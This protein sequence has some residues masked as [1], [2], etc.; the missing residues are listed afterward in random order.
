MENMPAAANEEMR[1]IPLSMIIPGNNPRKYFDPIAMG[2]L[3]KS[4]RERGVI[5]PVRLRPVGDKYQIVAGERRVR[6]AKAVFGPDGYIPAIVKEL[7]DHEAEE[8]ALVENTLRDDMSVTEEAKAAG[9][10]L[11]RCKGDRDEAARILAWP[12]QKLSRRL[13]LLELTEEVM[14]ALDERK[15]QTGH[16]E[17]LASVPKEKQN[18]TLEKIIE[19]SLSVQ[20][21][22]D[23]LLKKATKL[24]AAIFDTAGCGSCRFNSETQ[25]SLFTEHI[26]Q[27]YC[28]NTVCFD[29]K[30][31][32]TLEALKAE[33]SEEFP[34][35]R[36]IEAGDSTSVTQLDADGNLGVGVEQYAACKSCGDF[37]AT[38]S[39]LTPNLGAVTKSVCF[40][41]SCY[42]KKVAERIKADNAETAP[43]K[44]KADGVGPAS[45]PA[46]EKITAKPSASEI[47]QKVKEYRR[48]VW[49][50]IVKRGFALQPDNARHFVFSLGVSGDLHHVDQ[51]K[52]KEFYQKIADSPY[53]DSLAEGLEALS[54]LPVDKMD[55]L[56]SAIAVA[57]VDKLSETQIVTALRFLNLDLATFWKISADFLSLLTKSEIES[58]SIE[59]GLNKAMGEGFKK[60]LNGKKDELVK[61]IL[62]T[63]SF[64][65]QGA[66]PKMMSWQ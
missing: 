13:A 60:A 20:F 52:L 48:K 59:I 23:N 36:I 64:Q 17:L 29:K 6:A 11:S 51:I 43:S 27:G 5:Q 16:A 58:V 8:D 49:N 30:L 56:A 54:G 50:N 46:S 18:P 41:Q 15:I 35:V 12:I 39:S 38:I 53:P 34:T 40:N 33:L 47:S 62:S 57:S 1:R 14:T 61:T 26:G 45:K 25:A 21:C 65:W 3:V 4:I 2:D 31:R 28:T 7:S 19:K 44:E 10:T 22:R 42:Q 55:S 37:G 9:R 63:T 66:I 32:E 24:E